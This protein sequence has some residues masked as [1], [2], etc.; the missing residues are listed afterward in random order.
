MSCSSP[1]GSGIALYRGPG[2]VVRDKGVSEP[3][4]MHREERER[5]REANLKDNSLNTE[6]PPTGPNPQLQEPG[7]KEELKAHWT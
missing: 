4:T 7:Q 6:T 1:G 2:V 3:H 5:D